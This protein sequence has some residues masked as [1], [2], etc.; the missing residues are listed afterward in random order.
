VGLSSWTVC[1]TS[2]ASATI[3]GSSAIGGSLG[4]ERLEVASTRSAGGVVE[5]PHLD[6]VS[7]LD[8]FLD[9]LFNLI[10]RFL[11]ARYW[12]PI[13]KPMSCSSLE[14]TSVFSANAF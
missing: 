10:G 7:T 1:V 14:S 9:K 6:D 13:C 3:G 2:S 11:I 4:L 12:L 8:E 5:R